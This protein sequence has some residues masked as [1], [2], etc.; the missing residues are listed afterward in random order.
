MSLIIFNI[1]TDAVIRESIEEFKRENNLNDEIQTIFY[2]D[3][4]VIIGTNASKVQEMLNIFTR[5][6]ARIGL[7][8]NVE[9]TKAMI[10]NGGKMS[11]K[12]I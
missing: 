9:K 12:L 4:G 1:T 7:M 5:K 2:A 10:M 6:S 3:D 8:M 11:Q